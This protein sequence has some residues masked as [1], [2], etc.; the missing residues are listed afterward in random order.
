[1]ERKCKILYV[2]DE[3]GMNDEVGQRLVDEGFNVDVA[4][5][6]LEAYTMLI[7][8]NN[9]SNYD[10][11]ILDLFM[12]SKRFGEDYPQW[13]HL[14]GF[15][16]LKKIEDSE[17]QIKIIVYTHIDDHD[18]NKKLKNKKIKR[19]LKGVSSQKHDNIAAVIKEVKNVCLKRIKC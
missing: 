10:I 14:G 1:M 3:Y 11:V 9:A 8:D 6:V 5:D 4:S 17:I 12:D 7:E 19:F 15:C 16:I 18:I 2:E 13:K